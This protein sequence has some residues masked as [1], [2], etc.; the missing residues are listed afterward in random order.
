MQM[1]SLIR[2]GTLLGLL[3]LVICASLAFAQTDEVETGDA[4]I[5][6]SGSEIQARST[7]IDPALDATFDQ[8][9]QEIRED[10]QNRVAEL[11]TEMQSATDSDQETYHNAIAEIN[12]DTEIAILEVR[13]EQEVARGNNELAAKFQRAA[14]MM[15]NPDPRQT[16]DPEADRARFEQNRTTEGSNTR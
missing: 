15:R 6:Q 5:G 7:S 8:R 16:P 1:S 2:R 10:A 3:T 13:Y 12:R 4:A 9:I 11:Q 14:E